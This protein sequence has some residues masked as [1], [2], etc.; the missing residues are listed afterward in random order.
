MAT[1]TRTQR[2]PRDIRS[3]RVVALG[4]G[5]G[6][7]TVLRGL[8]HAL[9]SDHPWDAAQDRDR[10]TAIVAVTDDGGSSGR[11]RAEYRVP[12]PG[13]IRNCL[14][15]L[16]EGDPT[17]AAMFDF[18]FPGDGH[19][20]GHSLGNLMLVALAQLEPDFSEAVELGARLLAVRGRVLPATLDDVV[21][22][23][24]LADGTAVD[25]ESHLAEA[26][27]PIRR[28]SLRPDPTTPPA[29]RRA[30]E[31]AD[32]IVIGPG[33]LYS[34]LIAVLLVDGIAE[35]IIQSSARVVYVMNLM[36]EPGETD[37]HTGADH[38]VALRRHSPKL[39][40]DDVIINASAMPKPLLERYALKGSVP[41]QPDV[42]LIRAMGHR[43]ME[44]E[45][46]TRGNDIRHDADLLARS[47]ID[48]VL[49]HDT[50]DTEPTVS[51]HIRSTRST[52]T[53]ER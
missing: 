31:L 32:V 53:V 26:R 15:A 17:L 12:P 42:D 13:D 51:E 20:G 41:V 9:F 7:P 19:I 48:L 38:L 50:D 30:I 2:P 4:G 29:V 27:H 1:I 11:L 46:L 24:E 45:V 47:L 35:A 37:N 52:P 14:V 5:T 25:G 39:T 44:R 8:K 28:L 21:L 10:L 49:A 22:H 36:T 18:R 33:S 23:A 3:L 43:V 16:A 34:S 6:L 40:I